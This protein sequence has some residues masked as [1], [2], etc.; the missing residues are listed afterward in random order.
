MITIHSDHNPTIRLYINDEIFLD[1][2]L[3][4]PNC[5]VVPHTNTT[6]NTITIENIGD[7]DITAN[8]TLV[9]SWHGLI[10]IA[11]K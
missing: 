10:E 11:N 9:K 7:S 1:Q 2:T 6:N 5:V 8:D 3:A 4:W